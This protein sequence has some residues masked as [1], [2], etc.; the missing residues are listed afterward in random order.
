[1]RRIMSIRG[2]GIRGILPAS[3]LVELESQHGGLT[4]YQARVEASVY[5]SFD[6]SKPILSLWP[7]ASIRDR[8]KR[9]RILGGN[10]RLGGHIRGLGRQSRSPAVAGSHAGD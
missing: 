7:S 2:D 6:P 4:R 10:E 3:C 9:L 8:G 5:D 1:M